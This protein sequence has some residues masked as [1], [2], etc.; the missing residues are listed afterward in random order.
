MR[1]FNTQAILLKKY[2]VSEADL[3][4]VMLTEKFGKIKFGLFSKFIT[5]AYLIMDMNVK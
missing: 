3:S 2:K 5:T 4:L 1:D